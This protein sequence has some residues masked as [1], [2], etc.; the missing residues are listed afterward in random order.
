MGRRLRLLTKTGLTTFS[1][2]F[3]DVLI[4]SRC[5]FLFNLYILLD[6]NSSCS[7]ISSRISLLV[8]HRI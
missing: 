8:G 4:D 1:S 2:L 7:G 6:L 5:A 3:L